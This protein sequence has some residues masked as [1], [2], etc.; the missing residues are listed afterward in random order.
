MGESHFSSYRL[1]P[2]TDNDWQDY[3]PTGW[4]NWLGVP[5]NDSPR[6]MTAGYVDAG[7]KWWKA[8]YVGYQDQNFTQKTPLPAFHGLQGP[9][10]RAE[11]GD[12]IQIL[13]TNKL[14]Q[15]QKYASMH[16]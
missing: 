4:D 15:S 7:T 3:A 11:V 2:Q 12:M 16:S 8:A 13:F 10:L 6:A 5:F 1:E 14:N 9:T